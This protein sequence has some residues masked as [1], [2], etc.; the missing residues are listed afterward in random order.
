MLS[1]RTIK[2]SFCQQ[3]KKAKED[4]EPRGCE[5]FYALIRFL[6]VVE[7]GGI[8]LCNK[9]SMAYFRPVHTMGRN[10]MLLLQ[11]IVKVTI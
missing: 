11:G 3:F 9:P 4:T 7:A 1:Y 6:L 10:R 8:L 2:N 5:E